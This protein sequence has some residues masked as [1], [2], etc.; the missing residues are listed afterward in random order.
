MSPELPLP[1]KLL[2][3]ITY[4]RLI[5]NQSPGD[6]EALA[7]FWRMKLELVWFSHYLPFS[8]CTIFIN[9]ICLCQVNS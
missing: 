7:L 5:V 3:P 6:W 9:E 2:L 4:F 8:G 1:R